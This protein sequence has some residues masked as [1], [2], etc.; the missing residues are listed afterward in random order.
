MSVCF[1][2]G[3]EWLLFCLKL[4]Y[5]HGDWPSVPN[6][7]AE[8]WLAERE[9]VYRGI[10]VSLDTVS[11]SLAFYPLP[12]L[13]ERETLEVSFSIS[14]FPIPRR[15][16]KIS[17]SLPVSHLPFCLSKPQRHTDVISD[18]DCKSV[19]A[20]YNLG[21]WQS[22]YC[23]HLR[24]AATI[25]PPGTLTPAG[26]KTQQ[27]FLATYILWEGPQPCVITQSPFPHITSELGG[28]GGGACCQFPIIS[29]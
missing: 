27:G 16:W 9:S 18:S 8:A 12:I 15:R 14:P 4:Y 21:L 5:W 19:E 3:S 2:C 20:I 7:P 28:E 17:H 25:S 22:I 11:L 10:Y 23:I 6:T 1:F 26:W 24:L 13:R 29:S